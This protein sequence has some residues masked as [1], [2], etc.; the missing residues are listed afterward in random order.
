IVEKQHKVLVPGVREE[1]RERVV[2]VP[3][4]RLE[5]QTRQVTTVRQMAEAHRQKV[6]TAA[7]VAVPVC[8]PCTGLTA[9]VCQ[10]VPQIK[11][12]CVSTMRP[13]VEQHQE[14][15]TVA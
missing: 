4:T 9:M 1:V 6:M 10:I 11:E 5:Q 12:V 3:E 14:K 15:V 8:D 7:S 13:V 2:M